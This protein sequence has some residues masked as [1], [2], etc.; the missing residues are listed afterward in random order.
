MLNFSTEMPIDPRHTVADVLN[1]ACRWI[2]GS[3]HTVIPANALSFETDLENTFAFG[4]ED[5]TIISTTTADFQL[6]G[7][8]YR[9]AEKDGL[10]WTSTMVSRR[11]DNAH[12]IG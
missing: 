10:E 4:D 8:R 1:L 12:V 7:L 6:G 2:T 9:K 11:N 3:P 5:V